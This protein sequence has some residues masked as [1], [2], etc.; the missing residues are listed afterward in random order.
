MLDVEEGKG[1]SLALEDGKI[2]LRLLVRWLDDSIRGETERTLPP[3]R[4]YHVLFT[5]DGSRFADG[6]KIYVNG[7][8]REASGPARR[9]ESGLQNR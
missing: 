1:Y 5:Y 2:N 9:A 8:A 7:E 6:I 4:W 3:D